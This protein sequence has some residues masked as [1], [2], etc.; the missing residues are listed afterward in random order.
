[1]WSWVPFD[2]SVKRTIA[3]ESGTH[4]SCDSARRT[5]HAGQERPLTTVWFQFV[6]LR[7]TYCGR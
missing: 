4:H 3:T 7:P 2:T 1:M 6:N 5:S